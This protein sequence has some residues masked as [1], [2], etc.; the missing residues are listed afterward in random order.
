MR[1]DR[2]GEDWRGRAIKVGGVGLCKAG[3]NTVPQL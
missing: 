3:Q 2:S 1:G